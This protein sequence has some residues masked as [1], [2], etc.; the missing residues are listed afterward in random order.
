MNIKQLLE[1]EAQSHMLV[2]KLPTAERKNESV[3]FRR[4]SSGCYGR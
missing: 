3:I 4:R 1:V 2:G